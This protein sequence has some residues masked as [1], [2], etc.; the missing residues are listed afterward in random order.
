VAVAF[1][2]AQMREARAGSFVP[3]AT[4]YGTV[5][6]APV[7]AENYRVAIQF[8]REKAA[9]G[10]TVLSVPEDTSLYFFSDTV[11]PIYNYVM[12]PGALAP[13]KPTERA[14]REME[15]KRVRYLLWS[16]RNFLEYGVP[17]FGRDFSLEFGDYLR[18]HYQR[19]GPLTPPADIV[20]WNAIVWERKPEFRGP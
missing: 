1:L 17:F 8:M 9:L 4:K 20:E 15:E 5:R 19:V 6:V 13:G 12:T 14:I 7:L 16:N 10:E 3:F 2:S 18:A 11:S